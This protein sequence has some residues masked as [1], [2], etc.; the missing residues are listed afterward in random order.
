MMHKRIYSPAA[1]EIESVP[2]DRLII[3]IHH[4]LIYVPPVSGLIVF[5]QHIPETILRDIVNEVSQAL[6]D[7]REGLSLSSFIETL[8]YLCYK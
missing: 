5:G 7:K 4:S 8:Y 6:P 2:D 1:G 3:F